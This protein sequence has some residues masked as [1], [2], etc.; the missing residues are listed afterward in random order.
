MNF[1]SNRKKWIDALR[2]GNYQQT[3]DGYL[4]L[5]GKYCCLGVLCDVYE[6]E[7]GRKVE[8]TISLPTGPE[9]FGFKYDFE[10]LETF[11]QV[12]EWV[13]LRNRIGLYDEVDEV[14]ENGQCSLSHKNDYGFSFEEIAEIIEREPDG[15]FYDTVEEYHGK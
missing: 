13:G 14:D 12:M 9:T 4:H 11:P 6:K 1:K 15:L 8:A 3:T 2:S 5:D 7:T 10:T